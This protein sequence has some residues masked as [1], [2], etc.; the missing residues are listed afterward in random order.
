MVAEMRFTP[1]RRASR[2]LVQT[3]S[4]PLDI[5][6][7]T[8]L[9]HSSVWLERG[10]WVYRISPLALNS[11]MCDQQL[12]ILFRWD[13]HAAF[14]RCGRDGNVLIPRILSLSIFLPAPF[15]VSDWRFEEAYV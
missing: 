3:V 9:A 14:T 6:N 7:T 13:S 11:A 5:R 10:K 12:F 4:V 1:P 8:S 2:L 15:L